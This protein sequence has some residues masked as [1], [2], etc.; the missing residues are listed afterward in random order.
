MNIASLASN[1]FTFYS[2]NILLIIFL[3][4][5]IALQ[6]IF[7]SPSVSSLSLSQSNSLALFVEFSVWAQLHGIQN[8]SAHLSVLFRMYLTF[9]EKWVMC[10]F[11]L[12][13]IPSINF[14]KLMP[15]AELITKSLLLIISF[16][17]ELS[18]QHGTCHLMFPKSNLRW[19]IE[20]A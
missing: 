12:R 13:S 19:S 6:S 11:H 18:L 15:T 20:K 10:P 1:K 17:F 7:S 4:H 16:V 3:P 2:N 14:D 5:F 8:M 9:D